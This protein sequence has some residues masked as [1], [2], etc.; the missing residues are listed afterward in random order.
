MKNFDAHQAAAHLRRGP[1][2]TDMPLG[3]LSRLMEALERRMRKGK[4]NLVYSLRPVHE[5]HLHK[6]AKPGHRRVAIALSRP[7]RNRVIA[8][9]T[10]IPDE[11]EGD[12]VLAS[13]EADLEEV[14]NAN[15]DVFIDP[16]LDALVTTHKPTN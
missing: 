1:R 6:V 7:T 11:A 12:A 16:R 9:I 10:P 4:T 5:A 3:N 15:R 2:G 13:I 8:S 14:L